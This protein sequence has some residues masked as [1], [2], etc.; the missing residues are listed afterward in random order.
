MRPHLGGLEAHWKSRRLVVDS[1]RRTLKPKKLTLEPW[2]LTLEPLRF[3][4][5][6]GRLV[7]KEVHLN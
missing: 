7:L 6:P 4:L 1:W 3:T 5:E 2:R